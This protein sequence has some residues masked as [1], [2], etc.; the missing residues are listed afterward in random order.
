MIT[1]EKELA[2]ALKKNQNRI[3]IEGDL[4][5]KAFRIIATGQVAWAVAIVAISIGLATA[6]LILKVPAAPASRSLPVLGGGALFAFAFA[7][8]PV[9][10]SVLGTE[11]AISAVSIAFAT[12]GIAAGI[13]ALNS[14]RKYKIVSKR[15]NFLVLER[16]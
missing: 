12:G 9:A 8:Y 15:D 6:F 10:V 3:E 11:V 7:P 1:T 16:K 2:E 14:L 13:A 5:K 4:T